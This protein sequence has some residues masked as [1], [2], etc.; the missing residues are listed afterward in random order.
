MDNEGKAVQFK[1]LGNEAF[2]NKK[3]QEA[4]TYFNQAIECNPNDHTFFSNRASCYIN[5][6]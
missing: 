4:I 1:N 2:K 6:G 3:Y 5:I